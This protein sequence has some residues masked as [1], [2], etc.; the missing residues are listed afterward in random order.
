MGKIG[1]TVL[2]F[3][4]VNLLI[5][6][7]NW[8]INDIPVEDWDRLPDWMNGDDTLGILTSGELSD[9]RLLNG[10]QAIGG[11]DFLRHESRPK[12]GEP[13]GNAY[14]FVI[15]QESDAKFY[16]CGPFTKETLVRHWFKSDDLNKYWE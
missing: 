1:K 10:I 11:V 6:N 14:H 4:Q 13:E 16:L 12:E 2:T 15:K 7:G 9:P 5:R 8:F 3:D